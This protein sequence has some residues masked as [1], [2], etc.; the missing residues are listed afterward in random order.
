MKKL[1]ALILAAALALSLVAC[2][3]GSG[4]GD[5]NTPSTPSG[6]NGD[7]TS[8]DTP[9]GGGEDST[10]E[11]TQELTLGNTIST[12][13]WEFTLTHVT[14]GTNLCKET[15]SDD[16][17]IIDGDYETTFTYGGETYNLSYVAEDGRA[18]VAVAYTMK[19]NGKE[20]LD[21]FNQFPKLKVDYNGGYLFEDSP[22]TGGSLSIKVDGVFQ[23]FDSPTI[24]PLSPAAE[25]RDCFDV[26]IEVMENTNAP[27]K[28]IVTLDGID[29]IYSAR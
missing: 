8:T 25:Y 20:A 4:A 23:S 21:T 10:P 22:Y 3:G 14:F 17:M 2:G 13:N 5:T 9:S 12:D 26:P 11:E 19:Y 1:L 29:Y 6:G 27:V 16:Y 18:F 28:I 24:E 15:E 7:T